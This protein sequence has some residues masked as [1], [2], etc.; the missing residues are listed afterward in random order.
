MAVAELLI[1]DASVLIDYMHSELKPL[2]LWAKH[3]GPV[4][5]P[6][7]LLREADG[8]SEK[9]CLQL[10][11]QLVDP[12]M[13]QLDEVAENL[14]GLSFEDRLCLV[15]ARDGGL[16]CATND[17]RL[18]KECHCHGI[19]LMWGLEIMISLVHSALLDPEHA[20]RI[21]RQIQSNNPHHIT[22]AIIERFI[23]KANETP[24]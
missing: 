14:P 16:T 6:R 1:L 23:T 21:G 15:M 18:R 20:V 2:A 13:E 8:L 4:H 3:T 9:D 24:P 10:G 12:S 22:P 19:R 11:L 17:R 5:V 7:M